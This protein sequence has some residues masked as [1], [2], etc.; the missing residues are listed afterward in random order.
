MSHEMKESKAHK[1]SLALPLV[2]PALVTPFAQP[3]VAQSMFRQIQLQI[4]TLS[5]LSLLALLL[6]AGCGSAT[7]RQAPGEPGK[8][9]SGEPTS[10]EYQRIVDTITGIVGK[11]LDLNVGEVDMD[12]P[13]SKQKNPADELDVVEI[14]INVEDAFNIEIKEEDVGKT[15][16]QI[17]GDLSV[18]KLADIVSKKKSQQ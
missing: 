9:G 17:S 1:F 12:A 3:Q 15:L 4:K 7:P 18:K 8:V 13:L 16:G 6:Q 14:I 11:Q 5:M 10:S 2:L